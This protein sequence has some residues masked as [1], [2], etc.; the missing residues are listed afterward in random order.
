MTRIFLLFAFI[1]LVV[2]CRTGAPLG[3]S[4]SHSYTA[5]D[6][7]IT[8]SLFNDRSATVSEENIQKILDGSYQLPK[9]LRVAIVRIDNTP[10]RQFLWND[11]SFLKTQQSYLDLFT[12]KFRQSP[13]VSKIAVIPDIVVSKSSYT[14][15]REAAV[16]MQ[17]DVV[18]V[19]SIACDI[20][21]KYKVFSNP[22]LKA[23]AT[24]QLILLDVRT[25][26][27]PFSTVITRDAV[28]KKTKSEMD[29]SEARDRVQQQAVLLTIEE[30]GSKLQEFLK[31]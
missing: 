22:D 30:V 23:F 7:L 16:R 26:L 21:S 31:G 3:S 13:R 8:Q 24:T 15:I 11:E 4:E 20:Y 28:G 27:I 6:T 10:Q 9:Q 18:V 29:F 12:E 17:A 14:N 1:S 5:G 2:S 25:G 19:Y